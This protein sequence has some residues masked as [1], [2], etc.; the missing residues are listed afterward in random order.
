MLGVTWALDRNGN[1]R[2]RM[3]W[4]LRL[5]TSPMGLRGRLHHETRLLAAL[6]LRLMCQASAATPAAA[7]VRLSQIVLASSPPSSP[8][9]GDPPCEHTECDGPPIDRRP[10]AATTSA[11][12]A[13]RVLRHTAQNPRR[14]RDDRGFASS[15][16]RA[17]SQATS[18]ATCPR[19]RRRRHATAPPDTHHVHV[20][21]RRRRRRQGRVPRGG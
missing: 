7:V 18:A 21:P 1:V 2:G 8:H 5:C 14:D 11:A 9:T 19:E 17:P 13:A 20:G 4:Q 16:S 6:S 3:V 12:A 15:D 10:R